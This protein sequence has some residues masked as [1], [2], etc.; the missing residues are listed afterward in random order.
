MPSPL[1]S[2]RTRL[3]STAVIV[4]PSG[5]VSVTIAPDSATPSSLMIGSAR[6]NGGANIRTVP[7]RVR[8]SRTTCDDALALSTPC[9]DTMDSVGGMPTFSISQAETAIR[10]ATVAAHARAKPRSE[11]NAH[12]Q[13]RNDRELGDRP[14]GRRVGGVVVAVNEDVLRVVGIHH[15][16]VGRHDPT[17]DVEFSRGIEVETVVGGKARPVVR[18]A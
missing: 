5:V 12:P 13:A 10:S 8:S 17:V 11:I 9:S 7:L 2:S 3:S 4:W 15:A 6:S 1:R 18:A 14:S 16:H